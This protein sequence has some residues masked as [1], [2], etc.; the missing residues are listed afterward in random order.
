MF[1]ITGPYCCRIV[2]KESACHYHLPPSQPNICR[3]GWSLPQWSHLW[4]SSLMV[5]CQSCPQILDKDERE[6]QWQTLQLITLWQQLWL[7]ITQ[8][9]PL[10][11]VISNILGLYLI[12]KCSG[13]VLLKGKAQY[14]WAPCTNQFISSPFLIENIVYV[15]TKQATLMRSLTVLNLSPQ[16]VFPESS[17]VR[18]VLSFTS[19]LVY[20]WL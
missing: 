8:Y 14:S 6:W 18:L 12:M 7:K 13:E 3:Q 11:P 17:I 5:G 19:A 4:G 15:F 16:L 20:Y 9:N 2:M 10:W 1:H